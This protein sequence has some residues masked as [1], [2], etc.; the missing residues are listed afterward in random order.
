MPSYTAER[1]SS[2]RLRRVSIPSRSGLRLVSRYT[3]FGIH[4][5]LRPLREIGTRLLSGLAS[6]HR[7]P[8]GGPAGK[9]VPRKAGGA[10]PLCVEHVLRR[11]T[12]GLEDGPDPQKG[13][14]ARGEV[15]NPGS[16]QAPASAASMST[17]SC[18]A[19][20]I[21]DVRERVPLHLFARVAR[22]RPIGLLGSPARRRWRRRALRT[23]RRRD[24][25]R[26]TF[27]RL[28][29]ARLG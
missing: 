9:D 17:A 26:A 16:L 1:R 25:S 19:S 12:A 18:G 13:D 22:P 10:L 6:L 23:R 15:G 24:P 2:R 3:V 11:G 5:A 27:A 29:S 28:G 20:K 8:G 21:L 4:N 14:A 7:R